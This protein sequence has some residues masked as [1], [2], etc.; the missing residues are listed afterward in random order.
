MQDSGS[1]ATARDLAQYGMPSKALREVAWAYSNLARALLFLQTF[2]SKWLLHLLSGCI[3]DLGS[4]ASPR[5]STQSGM[6]LK[7]TSK[8]GTQ[9]SKVSMGIQHY[10]C[11]GSG[12]ARVKQPHLWN[13]VQRQQDILRRHLLQV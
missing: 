12:S 4:Y 3:Q 10:G 5:N 6:A 11:A 2:W 8:L 1:F 13:V 7:H 9:A